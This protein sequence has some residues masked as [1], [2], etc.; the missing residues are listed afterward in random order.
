PVGTPLYQTELGNLAPRVGMAY[1]LFQ[2][3]HWQTVV[4]GG[5]GIFYDL[6]TSELGSQIQP[7]FYPFG[8]SATLFG[9]GGGGTSTFPLSSSDAAPPAIT[10]PSPNNPQVVFGI[11]PHLRSPYTYE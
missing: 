1:E 10:A 2:N 3:R 6:A 11:D 4:R 8:A 7:T 9:T 5:F